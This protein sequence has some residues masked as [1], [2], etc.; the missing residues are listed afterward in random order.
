MKNKK[1]LSILTV[2]VII[3]GVVLFSREYNSP[4]NKAERFVKKHGPVIEQMIADGEDVS[5]Y[6]GV[7]YY[8]LHSDDTVHEFTL[9]SFG[10]VPSGRYSGCYYSINDAPAVY[11][12]DDFDLS[13]EGENMWSWQGIGDNRGTTYRISK[14][15]FF[16][17]M[18]Y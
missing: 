6:E 4:Q 15:W 11:A 14:N 13:L 12:G 16:F 18:S 2:V 17:E 3:A 5:D 9:S 10:I 7:K 1:L 8:D